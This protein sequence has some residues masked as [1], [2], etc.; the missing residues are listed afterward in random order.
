MLRFI[1]RHF[2]AI[3][4]CIVCVHVNAQTPPVRDEGR[5]L[6]EEQ[7]AREREERLLQE[8]PGPRNAEAQSAQPSSLPK[9]DDVADSEPMFLIQH[10]AL[11]GNTLLK[12]REVRALTAPFLGK[13]L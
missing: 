10:I 6:L 1:T 4:A 13:R 2:P 5:Q 8:T 9:P 11:K 12:V 3:V 7:R